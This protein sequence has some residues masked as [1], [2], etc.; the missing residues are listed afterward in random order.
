MS[1]NIS[2]FY[3]GK[4]NSA[5]EFVREMTECGAVRKIRAEEGNLRY[6]YFTSVEDSETVLLLDSWRDQAALD[7]HHASP[8]M[9]TISDL[10]EKYQLTM[11]VERSLS[12]EEGIPLND[13]RFIKEK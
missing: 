9:K 13:R 2:I 3:K 4:N 8:M 12:D 7:I 10:R 11:K 1:I 5:S 6:E